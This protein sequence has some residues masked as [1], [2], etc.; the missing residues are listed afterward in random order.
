[1]TPRAEGLAQDETANAAAARPRSRGLPMLKPPD[2]TFGQVEMLQ[3][4]SA[5]G[6]LIA[7]GYAGCSTRRVIDAQGES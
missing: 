7:D 4:Q 6:S 2:R 3:G 1:M 5:A